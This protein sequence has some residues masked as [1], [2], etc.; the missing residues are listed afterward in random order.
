M[1]GNTKQPGDINRN[2]KNSSTYGMKDQL[3]GSAET[4]EHV[5]SQLRLIS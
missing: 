2:T 1:V 5:Q 4:D 3:I